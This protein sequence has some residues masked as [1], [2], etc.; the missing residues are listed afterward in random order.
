MTELLKRCDIFLMANSAKFGKSK[1]LLLA[2]DYNLERLQAQCISEYKSLEDIKAIK[3]EPE[4]ANL[5]DR[6]KRMLL[7]KILGISPSELTDAPVPEIC[8]SCDLVINEERAVEIL[9]KL[10][11]L[12]TCRTDI[13]LVI[14]NAQIPAHKQLALGCTPVAACGRFNGRSN[15]S[16]WVAR[17]CQ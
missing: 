11:S 1:L 7:D 5:N 6:T 12:S 14:E 13:V 17:P 15:A 9:N 3:T 8:A 2:Q 4:Y 16:D 10:A